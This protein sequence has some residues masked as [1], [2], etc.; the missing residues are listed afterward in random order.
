MRNFVKLRAAMGAAAALDHRLRGRP[1]L[2]RRRKRRRAEL[3]ARRRRHAIRSRR[4]SRSSGRSSATATLDQLVTDALASNH[5]LRIALARFK[6]ARAAR[7]ETRLD[8]L[9][10]V[11]AGAGYTEQRLPQS[12]RAPGV[13]AEVEVYDASFDAFWELDFFGRVR[14]GVEAAN[15]EAEGAEASLRDAQVIIVAEVARTYFEL[16]GQQSELA[17]ARRNV[18][19]QR[20]TLRITDRPARRRPRHGARHLARAGAAERNAGLHRSA[21]GSG[22]PFH[23]STW[24]ADRPRAH[25]AD[26][27]AERT[28][29]IAGAAADRG[30]RQSC[31]SFAPPSRHPRRGARA[32]GL[33]G[34]HRRRGGGPV[35]AR[36]LRRQ[37]RLRGRQRREPRRLRHRHA[38]DRARAS[39]GRR[40]ISAASAPAS[41]APAPARKPRSPSTSRPSCG[42]W[43]KPKTRW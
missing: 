3:R 34:A 16:R 22:R 39:P 13:P 21:R 40:S 20:E 25:C 2:R 19:N 36:H 33:H 8:L 1:E 32:R 37:S 43:R 31:G 6:E 7:G 18:D 35:P 17:V 24:S 10:Q 14:R 11:T 38:P 5:D 42:R 12:Q 26:R 29:G 28:A 27:N 30:G 41:P 4:P 9:P 15:A 23:S